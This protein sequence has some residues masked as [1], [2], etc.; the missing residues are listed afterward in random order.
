MAAEA[1]AR[2]AAQEE[3]IE[4]LRGTVEGLE[5]ER[6]YYFRKLREVEILCASLQA[7]MEETE[8]LPDLTHKRIVE[9]IQ[10]ILY[11]EHDGAPI[12][13]EGEAP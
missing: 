5:H 6:N 11:A 9:D 7:R 4:Q 3:E 8:T 1:S 10:E 13:A 12:D 2:A